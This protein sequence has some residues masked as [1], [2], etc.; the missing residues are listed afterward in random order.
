MKSVEEKLREIR[1]LRGVQHEIEQRVQ[2]AQENLTSVEVDSDRPLRVACVEEM[3]EDC[4]RGRAA[5]CKQEE[6]VQEFVS[7]C[8]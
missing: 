3:I 4:T 8:L 1:H 7:M 2:M 5:I 6:M